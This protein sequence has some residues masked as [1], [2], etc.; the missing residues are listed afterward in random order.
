[1]GILKLKP[2]CKDYIWGG[3]ALKERYHKNADSERI[4][5]TW[6]LSCH[7]EGSCVIEGTKKALA[8]YIEE[9]P[10]ICGTICKKYSNFPILVK[11]ID[12]EDNLSIQVHPNDDYSMKNENQFGKTEMW[13]VIDAK[14]NAYIYYGFKK[15]LTKKQFREAINQNTLCDLLNC[16]PVKAGDTFFIEAGTVH[17]IGA[18]C[19]IA[20]VQ[21]SSNVTYR[22]YDYGRKNN[23]KSRQLH[24]EQACDVSN[25]WPV[26]T[27]LDFG[28]HLV[29]C[30]YFTVDKMEV[31][32]Q[33]TIE[34]DDSTFHHLLLLEGE[35]AMS[36]GT[37][38]I[39][40]VKGDSIFV[41]A[42][43]NEVVIEG[44]FTALHVFL[45]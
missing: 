28:N 5:E 40:A 37:E 32:G 31:I 22:V 11:L 6:E 42:E 33:M 26:D 9:K 21:Q 18:G 10:Q 44:N 36:C 39:Q 13:Y 25:F 4:A 17:A 3:T 24:I 38:F 43:S 7:P 41:E 35:C 15:N 23:G 27:R 19:L 20:E 1:M 29:K 16:V 2:V 34:V 30:E 45:Q 14:P 12:A 8:K